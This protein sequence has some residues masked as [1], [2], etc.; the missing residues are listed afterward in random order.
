MSI[1]VMSYVWDGFPASGSEMLAMLAL[2]D[3]C[4]DEG[5]SLHPSMRAVA[6]KIRVSEKQARRILHGFEQAGY[7]KVVGNANGGAPGATKQ[8]RLDVAKLKAL[9]DRA[10]EQK[11]PPAH[12]T[13]AV[14]ETPPLDVTPPIG[15]RVRLPPVGGYGS[16]RCPETAPMGGSQTTSE[17]SVNHQSTTKVAAT[18]AAS[19]VAE[20][21]D[22]ADAASSPKKRKSSLTPQVQEA[23]RATWDSYCSAYAGRY[24]VAPVKNAKVAGMVV[25]FAKRVP[26]AEAPD[27]AAWYVQHPGRFYVER[28]H[29]FDNLLKDAEKLRTEWATGRVV[30]ATAAR[31]SD[32]RGATASALEKLLSECEDAK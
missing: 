13:P 30:T 20:I 5:G 24:G 12:V 25:S 29:V 7:L 1:R 18:V 23:C 8:Y 31:Q 16:H 27:I 2:A 9:A 11:T 6:E 10:E 14:D 32:R 22:A 26:M 4:N 3:W 17:P 19:P 15:G 28:G 21:I